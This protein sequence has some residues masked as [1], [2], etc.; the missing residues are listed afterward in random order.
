MA[1]P[2]SHSQSVLP[3]PKMLV[4]DR[5]ERIGN[6]F[7]LD[8]RTRQLPRCPQ[9]SQPSSAR[10]S[11]YLRTLQD[12]PWQGLSVR[13]RLKVHRLRCRNPGCAQKILS[14]RRSGVV[15]AFGC[16]SDRLENVVKVIG[17]S[18]GG[19]PGSRILDRFAIP[20]SDDTVLRAVKRANPSSDAEPV[21][22][23]GVDDWAWRKG[24]RYGTILVDLERHRVV[25]LLPER[26]AESFEAWLQDHRGVETVNRDR[27][28]LYAEGAS[29][30]APDAR[31]IADRFHLVLNLSTAIERALEE[32]R[33]QLEL[34]QENE[35]PGAWEPAPAGRKPETLPETRKRQHRDRRL[36]RYQ[37]VV[38]LHRRGYTQRAIGE[39]VGLS[40]KT[41]R[42]WL[43]SPLF[44]ERKPA[45]GRRS[46]VREF[47]AYLK[48]RWEGCRNSTNCSAR[49]RREAIAA[50][51]KWS[52]IP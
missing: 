19:L 8:V 43:R 4:L 42:R 52:R 26:S 49:F 44:P 41:V 40:F 38:D 11:R 7:V 39:T 13:I 20:L 31:Q 51:V 37:K 15:R 18:V 12:L 3:D 45:S 50:A 48:Q 2:P 24:K 32:H 16:R 46:H 17:Y 27:C 5:I 9:C 35:S 36:E 14:E 34:P 22:H 30:G 10:H 21:R 6:Q 25:D 47:H 29:R 28:G 23:L 33:D 1:P